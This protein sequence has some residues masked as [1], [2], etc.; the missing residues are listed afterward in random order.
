MSE[1]QLVVQEWVLGNSA[2]LLRVAALL[3]NTCGLCSVCLAT[4][5]VGPR[6]DGWPYEQY[7]LRPHAVFC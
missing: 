1:S 4:C 2:I 5:N 6:A 3:W 7:I